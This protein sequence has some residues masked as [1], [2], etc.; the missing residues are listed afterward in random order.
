MQTVGLILFK[1][2]YIHRVRV[3]YRT[4][5]TRNHL[6]QTRGTRVTTRLFQKNIHITLFT[7]DV[8]TCVVPFHGLPKRQYV[9]NCFC[10]DLCQSQF[11]YLIYGS[12]E[13]FYVLTTRSS[14]VGS[15]TAT[16]LDE[17]GSFAN[18]VA[19]VEVLISD[20]IL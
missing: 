14:E 5:I 8:D 20:K 3:V 17:L 1:R 4:P 15:A 6:G 10:G 16:A 13:T 9:S 12:I 2:V 11:Y 7:S 18:E 19:G